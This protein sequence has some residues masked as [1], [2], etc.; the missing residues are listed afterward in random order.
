MK[1][2]A[3]PG[4]HSILQTCADGGMRDIAIIG[5]GINGCGIARDAA[6]R[7]LSVLLAE[8]D[9]LASG[10]SSASTKLI[11]GGLRY[12]E[13]YDF[14]LV[15]ESLREREVLLAMAP[16]IIRPMRFV[17]PH[18]RGL[19][20]AVLIRLGL[21][22]YDHLGGRR[23]LPSSRAVDLTRTEAGAA[24][25]PGFLRGFEYSD[26]WV[27]DARLVVL[28]AMDAAARGAE[29]RVRTEVVSAVRN[30]DHW[31]IVLRNTISG[32]EETAQA[33]A[34]VNA[35]GAWMAETTPQRISS[36]AAP[37]VRL[38]RGSHIVVRKLFDHDN[39]YIFQNSDRRIIFAIPYEQDFTLI[40]T[41]D[42]DFTGD[43]S[44]IK[45]SPEEIDYLCG[46]A[47]EYF[48]NS[49]TA[50]DVVWSYS[51][52]RSLQDDGRTF[53][54]DATR[55]F[56]LV[57][58]GRHGE[59]P[60][61]SVVGGK[62]TTYRHVAEEALKMLALPHAGAAWTRGAPLP[63]G[64]FGSSGLN[65]LAQDLAIAVPQLGLTTANR[66]ARTYGTAARAIAAHIAKPEDLGIH[67][68]AGLYEREVVHLVEN[69][70]AMTADDIL[71][72]RTKLGLRLNEEERKR[73]SDWLSARS[74]S[75]VWSA[76]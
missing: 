26:C 58:D 57:L 67:F 51:G 24:L 73:L 35:S 19:R 8:K 20:P 56:A 41:T 50:S 39:A 28:N 29:I 10:T 18:H 31:Q 71:W 12:L 9:D 27:D 44:S 68:G 25:K 13:H 66:L 60:L 36:H 34:L 63:G 46:A 4:N 62:I 37:R 64:D 17:L 53:A 55:D 75:R 42:V 76:N 6:G 16:H 70:W 47:N 30:G 15:R 40:G 22:L 49:I 72:R 11:H 43:L 69:E 23:S 7:G 52:V 21:F 65:Q 3:W 14:R 54:Q 2:V 38:V 61:L 48:T 33:R 5:G 45:I 59:P 32:R 1:P 74:P